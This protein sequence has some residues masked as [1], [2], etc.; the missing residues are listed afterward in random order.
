MAAA[1]KDREALRKENPDEIEYALNAGAKLWKGT[2]AFFANGTG[3]LIPARTGTAGDL[4]AG[5]PIQ[6]YDNSGGALGDVIGIVYKR[7]SFVF[8]MATPPTIALNGQ[9]AYAVDDST[10]TASST[11]AVQVGTFVFDRD[12]A[13]RNL[14]RVNVAGAVK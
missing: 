4:F 3:G 7:G 8:N 6:R 14:V 12:L 5:V 13:S 2:L 10:V 11:G 9:P 1:S